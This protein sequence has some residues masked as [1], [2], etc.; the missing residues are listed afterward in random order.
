MIQWDSQFYWIEIYGFSKSQINNIHQHIVDWAL[1]SLP[2]IFF[3]RNR[4]KEYVLLISIVVY[5]LGLNSVYFAFPRY[6][7]PLMFILFIMI[8]TAVFVIYQLLMKVYAFFQN[9]KRNF[10]SLSS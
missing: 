8:A 4:W 6:N 7:Q 2:A 3:M 9:R 5:N 1:L 10:N